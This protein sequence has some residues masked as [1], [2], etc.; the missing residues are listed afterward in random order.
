MTTYRNKSLTV[1]D[2]RNYIKNSI[3]FDSCDISTLEIK[4]VERK[5]YISWCLYSFFISYASFDLT[6]ST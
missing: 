1:T 3:H 4:Q 6:G 5:Q 2:I